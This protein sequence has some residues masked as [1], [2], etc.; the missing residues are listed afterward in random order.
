MN[1]FSSYQDELY[2]ARRATIRHFERHRPEGFD[3]Y[4]VGWNQPVGRLQRLVPVLV[5]KYPSYRGTVKNKWEVLPYYRFS[6]CY[7]NNKDQNGNISEKVFDSMRCGC[8]PIYWGAPNITDYVDRKALID[9]RRFKSDKELE[10]Y[11]TGIS[12]KEYGYYQDAIKTYLESPRFAQFL[13]SAFADII[14]KV[15]K[16]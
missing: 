1:K 9:R 4:G 2:T 16:L 5:Q 8:V 7:E 6:I 15:L 12:E 14:I 10:D 13:P 3:L 11:I